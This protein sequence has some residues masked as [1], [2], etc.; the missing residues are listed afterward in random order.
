MRKC[1]RCFTRLLT[2]RYR[3]PNGAECDTK[4]G[5]DVSE[6]C[7]SS[8]SPLRSAVEAASKP[9]AVCC[10]PSFLSITSDPVLIT[11]LL[12][13]PAVAFFLATICHSAPSPPS[14]PAFAAK[15]ASTA[16]RASD[17]CHML[18]GLERSVE[19]TWRR[20]NSRHWKLKNTK[21]FHRR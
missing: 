15:P 19:R 13:V 7:R 4:I 3:A 20:H 10:E 14:D 5:F 2:R 9:S 18:S 12:A 8:A 16:G 6:L 11:V 21:G 17:R 1:E